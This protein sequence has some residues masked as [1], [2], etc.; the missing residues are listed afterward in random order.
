[1]IT[2]TGELDLLTAARFGAYINQFVHRGRD[3]IIVDLTGTQFMDSAGLQIL[4][5]AERRVTRAARQLT[6]ICP[7]GPVR[8]IIEMARLS[9]T[10]GVR[11]SLG[12]YEAGGPRP[13]AGTA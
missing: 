8:R 9:E 3:D 2:V 7:P 11:S 13:G 4:L 1:V 6:V 12:G 10:L 5:S